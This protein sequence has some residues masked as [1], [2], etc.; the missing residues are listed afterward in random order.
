ML[1]FKTPT[2]SQLRYKLLP[3][4]DANLPSIK[5]WLAFLK[6]L[7]LPILDFLH[8]YYIR[9]ANIFQDPPG[10]KCEHCQD[11]DYGY[12]TLLTT[13][14]SIYLAGYTKQPSDASKTILDLTE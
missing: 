11:A 4:N 10:G 3:A 13:I 1:R 5:S 6:D 12:S 9:N 2:F 8:S 14:F 7:F